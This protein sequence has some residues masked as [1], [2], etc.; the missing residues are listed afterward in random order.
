V[1][2][3]VVVISCLKAD[4]ERG[5]YSIDDF[6]S[7]PTSAL[8]FACFASELKDFIVGAFELAQPEDATLMGHL[9]EALALHTLTKSK[10]PMR[11]KE[12]DANG[13]LVKGCYTSTVTTFTQFDETES[14]TWLRWKKVPKSEIVV[15][16]SPKFPLVDALG[17]GSTA[18]Q[19]TISKEHHYKVGPMTTFLSKMPEESAIASIYT[20]VPWYRYEAFGRQ[21]VTPVSGNE[22]LQEEV[23]Q[24]VHQF[25]VELTKEALEESFAELDNDQLYRVLSLRVR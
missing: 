12:W 7:C 14:A 2:P 21:R 9:F 5:S 8:A 22:V 24:K 11:F 15:P 23:D 4:A 18:W 20:M 17:C 6:E 16:K 13:N 19:M 10:S 25:V 1:T 3:S